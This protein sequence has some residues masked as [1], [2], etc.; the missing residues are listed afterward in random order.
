MDTYDVLI[1]GAGPAGSACAW[2]L[3][4]SGLT[5]MI[6]DKHIF[7]RDK[8]CGGWITP[9]VFEELEINPREYAGGRVL[10]PFHGFRISRMDGRE[11]ETDYGKPISYG[12]RRCE[13]DDFLL[14]RSGAHIQ[15]GMPLSRLERSGE[16]WIANGQFRAGL[17]VG[18]GGHFC[19]VARY[20]GA[21]ARNEVSVAAQE[22]EFEMSESQQNQCSI[23]A[24]FPELYFC[25]DMKGYGWCVRK[26]NFLNV[27]LGRLDSHA[28][29][30]HVAGFVEFLNKKGKVAFDLPLA[31][32]GHSYLL[33]G[34]SRR[35]LAEDGVLL[36][37][38]A[39][40]LA[41]LQSGEGIRPAIESGLIAAQAILSVSGSKDPR[42]FETYRS[43]LAERFGK[44]QREWA[45]HVG[46][47]LPTWLVS[48]LAQF[49]VASQWFSRHIILERWF[50]HA[51][52]PGL[53]S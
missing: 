34:H 32:T 14:K 30:K 6:L 20:R 5:T 44:S 53:S 21:N 42:L 26:K 48:F 47:L 25:G 33:Y 23:R 37:G 28:L 36:I 12:I 17:V 41:Y 9:P 13:F 35:N 49:L 43:L 4:N 39:A 29:P 18:A 11:V 50:L 10:Q 46:R 16:D 24:E 31:M 2:K 40:G 7:P 8:V 51:N 45:F 15:E 19:P 3:R 22:I 38:D 52:E 1:V 27:G